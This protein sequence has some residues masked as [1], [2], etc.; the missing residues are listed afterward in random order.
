[1]IRRFPVEF[2]VSAPGCITAALMVLILPLP[3]LAAV[4]LA[5]AVHEVCHMVC[6]CLCGIPIY[7]IYIGTQGAAIET[8]ALSPL[9]ELLCAAAGPAGSFLCLIFARHFPM[10]AL[11]GFLQG[12]YNLLPIYPLDG[13]RILHSIAQF[14]IPPYA[15][16]ICKCVSQFATVCILGICLFLYVKT[17]IPLFLLLGSYFLMCTGLCRKTPCKDGQN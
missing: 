15:E 13:G 4:F 1:M 12:I 8:A 11:C 17:L 7:R 2:S 14:L 10:L 6:L 9:Q 5:A 16:T 3:W